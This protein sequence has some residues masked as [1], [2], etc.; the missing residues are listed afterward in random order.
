MLVE[1]EG[2]RKK[3][4]SGTDVNEE[5][6]P[7]KQERGPSPQCNNFAE[8]SNDDSSNKEE[9]EGTACKICKIPWI[10]LREKS[11]DRVQCDICDEYICVKCYFKRDI[12]ADDKFL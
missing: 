3:I 1:G 7:K 6:P 8:S 12:S 9:D 5:I 10:A 4:P 2:R 11:G